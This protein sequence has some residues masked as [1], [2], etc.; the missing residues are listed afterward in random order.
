MPVTLPAEHFETGNAKPRERR[1]DEIG[2]DSE[3]L[4]DDFR[5]GLA[6]DR[7][8]A[9]A[10]RDLRRFVGR[11]E[12]RAA[13]VLR[14]G[15]RAVEA[16]EVID[17]V[18]VVEVR[19]AARAL[20]QPTEV[21]R[22]DH[23]PSIQRHPP[24]LSRRAERVGRRADGDVEVE[25]VLPRP[26]VGAVAV[27]HERQ[28]AE[29]GDA[30]RPF[31]RLSPLR[32]GEPLQVLV[33]EHLAGELA[34]DAID[35]GRITALQIARPFGPGP[36]VLAHVNRAEQAVVL[37][38][39]RLLADEHPQRARAMG[40]APPFRFDEALARRSRRDVADITDGPTGRRRTAEQRDEESRPAAAG[41]RLVALQ[42]KCRSTRSMPSANVGSGGSRLTIT[43]DS[44]GKSK[45]YPGCAS[46]PSVCSIPTTRS[47]SVSSDG[48]CITPYHPPS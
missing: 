35:G 9:F 48:T 38:P 3:I 34:A 37:D 26:D 25:L 36:F 2:D 14:I 43:N 7:E 8:H 28:I 39:P 30:A 42:A 20:A 22:R 40:V 15:V 24:V 12:E 1:A 27:D 45:K 19:A 16:D 5:A 23:V 11:R 18:S 33:K 41:H 46:T 32:C 13:A 44:R 31:T 47:S 6:K 21:L 29:Q 17:A 4:G 10:E